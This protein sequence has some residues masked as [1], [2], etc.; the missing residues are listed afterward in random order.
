MFENVNRRTNGRTDERTKSDHPEHSSG[1]LK[2]KMSLHPHPASQ[3]HKRSKE[4]PDY[5]V[6]SILPVAVVYDRQFAELGKMALP[7][8]V[9][10]LVCNGID[11]HQHLEMVDLQDYV[12]R[13]YSPV[14]PMGSS[15]VSLPSHTFTR[16]A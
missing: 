13:F 3:R 4:L 2:I 11:C 16:Q 12:L 14:N 7:E 9:A 1:E 5:V 10:G 15:V 6:L 8:A